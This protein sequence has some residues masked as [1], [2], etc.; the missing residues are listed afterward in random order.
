MGKVYISDNLRRIL[1]DTKSRQQLSDAME[2]TAAERKEN[3]P[4]V[5]LG[6]ERFVVLVGGEEEAADILHVKER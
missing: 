5:T 1:A 2:K 3:P 6:S 4:M